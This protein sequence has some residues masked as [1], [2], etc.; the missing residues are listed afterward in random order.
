[1]RTIMA[2]QADMD[3]A[4]RRDVERHLMGASRLDRSGPFQVVFQPIIRTRDD[5]I[6]GFEA[7]V[8]W[9]WKDTQISPVRFVKSAEE[10]GLIVPIGR[11]V[12]ENACR[13]ILEW[14]ERYGSA[15]PGSI[16]VNVSVRQLRVPGYVEDVASVLKDIG[17]SPE[18]L[19]LEIT[20]SSFLADEDTT[21]KSDLWPARDWRAYEYG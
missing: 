20:E 6:D 8:R 5:Y 13:Q 7:L 19:C 15:G 17:L 4:L 18:H 14:Q 10:S 16:N 9:R 2:E 3:E 21:R 12:L 1:M 11:W